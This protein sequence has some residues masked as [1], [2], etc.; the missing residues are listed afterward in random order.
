MASEAIV[1]ETSLTDSASSNA[2]N[3]N[4][5]QQSPRRRLTST[6]SSRRVAPNDGRSNRTRRYNVD[7]G[8]NNNPFLPPSTAGSII[9]DV[10]R[11]QND[12]NAIA[13]S[14]SNLASSHMIR[15]ADVIDDKIIQTIQDRTQAERNGACDE[16]INAYKNKLETLNRE[17]DLSVM[18]M[19]RYYG[20]IAETNSINEDIEEEDNDE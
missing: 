17:R 10:N 2:N 7:F 9:N 1:T 5:T 20:I 11:V 13:S 12:F 4:Y 15:H 3:N 14:I 16:L 8:M 19:E 18:H 6:D